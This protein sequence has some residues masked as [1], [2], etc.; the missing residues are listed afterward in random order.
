MLLFSLENVGLSGSGWSSGTLSDMAEDCEKAWGLT[1]EP[2]LHTVG[3]II[4]IV[5]YSRE[6]Y[7]YNYIQ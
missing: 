7:C 6:D 2:E 3:R 1:G 4:A 5:T